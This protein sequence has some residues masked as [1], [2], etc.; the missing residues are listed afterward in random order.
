[1]LINTL[2]NTEYVQRMCRKHGLKLELYKKTPSLIVEITSNL[3]PFK[4]IRMKKVPLTTCQLEGM[5]SQPSN[6][7]SAC[8]ALP[9]ALLLDAPLIYRL[10]A[11]GKI[12]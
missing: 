12:Y 7:E 8:I 2:S 5:F 10:P 3:T 9:T 1:M 6:F 11:P 4:S